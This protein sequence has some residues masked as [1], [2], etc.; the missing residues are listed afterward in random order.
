MAKEI[1]LL[2]SNKKATVDDA[3]ADYI[4]QWE[5]WLDFNSGYAYRIE[6]ENFILMQNQIMN[7]Y[8]KDIN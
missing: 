5:W 6:E 7:R 2:N 8:N 3:D 4:N 1:T